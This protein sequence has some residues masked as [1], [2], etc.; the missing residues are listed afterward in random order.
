MQRV[1][2]QQ[3][4]QI[5]KLEVRLGSLRFRA[6]MTGENQRLMR[7]ERLENLLEG[8]GRLSERERAQ[9][10]LIR[11][12]SNKLVNLAKRESPRERKGLRRREYEVNRELKNWLQ[13]SKPKEQRTDEW[14]EDDLHWWLALE[15]LDY[16]DVDVDDK[17]YYVDD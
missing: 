9:L 16:F 17:T 5:Q 12:N 3:S 6:L 15:A 1:T 10:G 13:H 4:E 11:R 8:H 2:P 7:P 14:K